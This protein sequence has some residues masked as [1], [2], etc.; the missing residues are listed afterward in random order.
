[1]VTL[2]GSSKAIG[3]HNIINKWSKTTIATMSTVVRVI[4]IQ[5]SDD[6]STSDFPLEILQ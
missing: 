6:T 3:I 2:I 4:K 5:F 1:M